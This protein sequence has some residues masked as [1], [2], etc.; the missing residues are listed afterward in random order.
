M[1][2]SIMNFEFTTYIIQIWIMIKAFSTF[3]IS[4]INKLDDKLPMFYTGRIFY[5]IFTFPNFKVNIE[6]LVQVF[7]CLKRTIW[8]TIVSRKSNKSLWS[9]ESKDFIRWGNTT[10]YWRFCL[11]VSITMNREKIFLRKAHIRNTLNCNGAP[12]FFKNT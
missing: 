4:M 2:K 3:F 7:N 5:L 8:N 11:F 1:M 12:Y 6:I 10:Q 9:I